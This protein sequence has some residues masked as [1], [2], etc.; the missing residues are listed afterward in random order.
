MG[1]LIS[2]FQDNNIEYSQ[3]ELDNTLENYSDDEQSNQTCNE[4]SNHIL[5][6]IL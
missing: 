5:G 1:C 2:C 6:R 3:I 4:Q